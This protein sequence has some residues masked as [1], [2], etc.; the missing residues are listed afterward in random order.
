MV[1]F[2]KPGKKK[3]KA[4]VVFLCREPLGLVL[5]KIVSTPEEQFLIAEVH[6]A[7]RVVT[8]ISFYRRYTDHD[9]NGLTRPNLPISSEVLILLMLFGVDTWRMPLPIDPGMGIKVSPR[10][11]FSPLPFRSPSKS[12]FGS[13]SNNVRVALS[14]LKF[15]GILFVFLN[16]DGSM[17]C[18]TS[19]W[20]QWCQDVSSFWPKIIF[21]L[22]DRLKGDSGQH[23]SHGSWP[24]VAR[25]SAEK[26]VRRLEEA[27]ALART[28]SSVYQ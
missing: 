10:S 11:V 22:S 4:G 9:M 23:T 26:M 21:C 3:N 5:K 16:K 20:D 14:I 2:P 18:A 17:F 27:Q 19:M 1:Q 12:N 25:T 13:V 15:A 8:V 7:Q 24:R 6:E 28:G